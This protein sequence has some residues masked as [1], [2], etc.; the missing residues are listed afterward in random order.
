MNGLPASGKTTTAR[1]LESTL[2]Y[3]Y[4]STNYTREKLKLGNL[5][6]E[7]QKDTVY[8]SMI[9]TAIHL[10]KHTSVILDATFNKKY[11]RKWVFSD[12]SQNSI[13]IIV[14]RC[15]CR[16]SI[17]NKRIN[18]RRSKADTPDNQ[19]KYTFDYVREE[20]E[21]LEPTEYA[22]LKPLSYIQFDTERNIP[23]IIFEADTPDLQKI[24]KQLPKIR[25][26]SGEHLPLKN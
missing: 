9:L 26:A 25:R 5:F 17:S 19:G 14:I 12:L 8:R 20:D 3:H 11:R 21:S 2:G 7:V 16:E 6:D 15:I 13:P 24:L 22:S 1:Y 10:L 23:K 18:E 4:L